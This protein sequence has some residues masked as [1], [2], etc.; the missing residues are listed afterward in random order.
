LEN[1]D[2]RRSHV[3]ER[4]TSIDTLKE[5]WRDALGTRMQHLL[6]FSLLALLERPGSTIAD[7]MPMFL[8]T[9]IRKEVVAG[10][11]DEQVKL[12][13]TSEISK[14]NCKT[15]ADGVAPIANKLKAFL[16]YPV[17]CTAVCGP[18]MATGFSKI[19]DEGEILVINLANRFQ[20]IHVPLKII[21][22]TK[23]VPEVCQICVPNA[24][25]KIFR[26]SLSC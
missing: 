20:P 4:F 11:T 1:P 21:T 25:L 10:S 8:N 16:A 6:W 24:C 5:Q 14:T 17:V 19:M 13:W 3:G 22:R 2:P 7:V 23:T 18:K 12:F 15:A 9:G 26:S